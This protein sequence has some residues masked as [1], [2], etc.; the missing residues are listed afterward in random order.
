MH[1]AILMTNTDES[2]FA[3]LHPKDGVKFTQL[4]QRARPDWQYSVF[5]VKDGTFPEDT[6]MIDGFIITGSPASVHDDA[7][8]IARLEILIQGLHA[9]KRPI[10]GACFGHQVIATALG[11]TVDYNPDGWIMGAVETEILDEAN[12]VAAYAAHKEQVIALPQGAEITAK[13]K[14]CPIAGFGLGNH[15]LTTQYHP[16]M[17]KAFISALLEE[18][19]PELGDTVTQRANASLVLQPDLTDWANRIATFFE[20]NQSVA[21]TD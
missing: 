8:W 3:Q 7:E 12:S 9:E 14:G 13:T 15:I 1:I 2:P 18:I 10:F 4:M 16:E 6:S 21:Q 19:G 17:T 5:S 20:M 11:G